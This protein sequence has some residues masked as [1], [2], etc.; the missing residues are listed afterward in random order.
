VNRRIFA[1][2]I[3]LAF[4]GLLTGVVVQG[5]SSAGGPVEAVGERLALLLE[6][7]QYGTAASLINVLRKVQRDWFDAELNV[8]VERV[9]AEPDDVS[10]MKLLALFYWADARD[11]LAAPLYETILALE[12]DSVFA[13]LFR[14]SSRLYSGDGMMGSAD[15][16][17]A[18]NL[19]PENAAVYS[20][21]GSTHQQMGNFFDA[22]I[23]LDRAVQLDP[24]DGRSRYYRGMALLDDQQFEEAEEEFALALE[25]NPSNADAYYDLAR[26]DVALNADADA[27]ARLNTA[28]ALNPSFD[29]ALSFRGAMHEWAGERQAA[30]LDYLAYLISIQSIAI[31]EGTL[32]KESPATVTVDPGT[33]HGWRY[34]GEAGETL[35]LSAVS[36]DG[37]ANPILVLL[38][39]VTLSP[40]DAS[41]EP[42]RS[43]K[44]AL[45]P[46]VTLPASGTYF[47]LVALADA[48]A[49]APITVTVTQ[50]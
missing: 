4:L 3:A 41:S 13:F 28:L 7:G 47:I 26:A 25:Y 17:Q 45:I 21:I 34:E 18:V 8:L 39:P 9:A 11:N 44:N 6:E 29:L 46:N 30:A 2:L 19:E 5:Q 31:D 23:A 12:P 37:S 38:D 35:A 16:Q 32:T 14:G 24:T 22:L 10:A 43:D 48:V 20:I 15:F 50:P 27:L 36:P 33:L 1:V 40:L 49:S 42:T